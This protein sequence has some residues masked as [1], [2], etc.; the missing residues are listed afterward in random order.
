MAPPV[1][2]E[3]SVDEIDLDDASTEIIRKTQRAM[4][5]IVQADID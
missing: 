4:S 1:I 3:L 2:P 5:G